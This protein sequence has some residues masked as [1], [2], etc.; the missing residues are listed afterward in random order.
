M[1]TYRAFEERGARIGV[2]MKP[3]TSN[4]LSK[5]TAR[6]KRGD[7]EVEHLLLLARLADPSAVPV[8]RELSATHRWPM[9]KRGFVPLGMWVECIATFLTRG[10]GAVARGVKAKKLDGDVALGLLE[11]CS[12]AASIEACI[13]LAR[14]PKLTRAALEAIFFTIERQ[15]RTVIDARVANRARLLAHRFLRKARTDVD[16]SAAYAVLQRLGDESS[17]SLM[18][19][20]KPE[21]KTSP[22]AGMREDAITALRRRLGLTRK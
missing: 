18:A 3:R 12:D 1:L 20:M 4:V 15:R 19:S 7:V 17:L 11:E 10:A 22:F 6:A 14:D 16:R 13:A 8:L 2:L 21:R 5:I 9:M